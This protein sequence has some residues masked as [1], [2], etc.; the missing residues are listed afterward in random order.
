MSYV[1]AL[2]GFAMFL[3]MAVSGYAAANAPRSLVRV[4]VRS[5]PGR[6]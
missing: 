6:R 2:A 4:R 3:A 1:I 5:N